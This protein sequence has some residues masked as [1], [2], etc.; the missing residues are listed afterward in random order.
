MPKSS[1]TNSKPLQSGGA[2]PAPEVGIGPPED[3]RAS[4]AGRRTREVQRKYDFSVIRTLRQKKGW[5]I[6]EFALR[7]GIS[8]APISRIETNLVKPNLETLDRMA[9]GLGIAT[10]ALLALAERPEIQ[11]QKCREGKA[12]GFALRSLDAEACQLHLGAGRK[13][14]SA[15]DP[16]AYPKDLVTLLVMSGSL[17]ATVNGRAHAVATGES[18]SFDALFPHRYVATEDVEFLLLVRSRR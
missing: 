1:S 17:E 11:V 7:C 13:G 4:E 15:S 3:R 12:G 6:E 5:T 16:E 14:A 2:E 18:L 9:E 8:Y 10:Y